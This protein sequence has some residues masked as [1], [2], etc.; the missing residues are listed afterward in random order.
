MT[1]LLAQQGLRILSARIY[2][3]ANGCTMN[4]YI[5][6]EQDGDYVESE[7]RKKEIIK[8]LYEGLINPE[9][10]SDEIN[11][12]I[13]RQLRNFPVEP[14]VGFS[15]DNTH[16]QTRMRLKA[17]DTPG[18]LADISRVFIEND[19][20]IHS[21][22]IATIGAEAEDTFL[23]SDKQNNPLSDSLSE[24][25]AGCIVKALSD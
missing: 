7:Q 21:A 8:T 23:I 16:Q 10:V 11:T 4:S 1:I 20:K 25:L 24:K 3:A 19:I 2:S 13:H 12:H 6:H 5:V 9:Q 17:N 14:E 15:Y 18:L 22:K